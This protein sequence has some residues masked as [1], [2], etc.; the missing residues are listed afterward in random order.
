M[1]FNEDSRVKIPTILHLSSFQPDHD[2]F[3]HVDSINDLKLRVE[4]FLEKNK[5]MTTSQFKEIAKVSRKYL[6]PLLEYLDRI[7]FTIRIEDK[8]RLRA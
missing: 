6:I 1:S 8:R 4:K 2:L 3:F 7:N 5:E